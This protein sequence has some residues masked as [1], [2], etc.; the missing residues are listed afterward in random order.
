MKLLVFG[1][2]H[3]SSYSSIIR[4]RGEKYSMR[5]E[6][7][8][9]SMKWVEDLAYN[10]GCDAI[11][12]L[13]DFFDKA[14]LNSEELTA[15]DEIIFNNIP[16][17]FLVGNHE[18]GTSNL[19]ISSARVLGLGNNLNVIDEPSVF[20]PSSD[21]QLC[22]LPYIFEA[23]RKTLNEYFPQSVANKIVFSHNDLKGIQMGKF[24]S[25]EGFDI[26]D[27][28]ANC[29]LFINGHLHNGTTI[30]KN[31]INLGNLTGQNF[32]EDADRF[33]HNVLIL[34]TE[35]FSVEWIEN[36]YAFRFYKLDFSDCWDESCDQH[37]FG[38]LSAIG[39]NAVAT[40]KVNTESKFIVEDLIS[41]MPNIVE[42]RIIVDMSASQQVQFIKNETDFSVDHI[43]QFSDYV[44]E[45][46][47]TSK[48]VL[49]ELVVVTGG[50]S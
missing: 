5:I 43:K 46:L 6:N 31:I 35:Q 37:I 7:I 39:P 32:S 47:G 8:L 20:N 4:S 50:I 36:P 40:I 33:P 22:F 25:S 49:E 17:Y 9:K 21:T 14:E 26:K 2:V 29:R 16:H 30:G 1:D 18:V 10:F 42:S 3:Y 41:T 45:Q 34:D 15:L 27:I 44:K 19:K 11:V 24:L 23:D 38:A 28:E 48:E 12:G 13:G